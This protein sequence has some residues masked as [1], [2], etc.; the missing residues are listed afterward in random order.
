MQQE[1]RNTKKF[2]KI[3]PINNPSEEKEIPLSNILKG[4][5]IN[6]QHL[7]AHGYMVTDEE[8]GR[9]LNPTNPLTPTPDRLADIDEK[10]KAIIK[11]NAEKDA[12]IAELEEKLQGG[13]ET[14][15]EAEKEEI[16]EPKEE[17][18]AQPKKAGRKP[19]Q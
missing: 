12:K 18:E 11:S 4:G 2:I 14:K 8:Y 1:I 15:S 17:T 7:E 19:K 5:K 13:K 10:I 6:T 16:T 3:A 9:K